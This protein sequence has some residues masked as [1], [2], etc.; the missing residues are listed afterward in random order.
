M[1]KA[2]RSSVARIGTHN[3]RAI[4]HIKANNAVSAYNHM[5]GSGVQGSDV[6]LLPSCPSLPDELQG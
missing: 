5:T 3:A 1:L 4:L 6:S 2:L